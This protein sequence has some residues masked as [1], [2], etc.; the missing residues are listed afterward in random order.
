[1]SSEWPVGYDRYLSFTVDQTAA[2]RI[3]FFRP[4][5]RCWQSFIS[6]YADLLY[7]LTVRADVQPPTDAFL[8][9]C[10]QVQAQVRAFYDAQIAIVQWPKHYLEVERDQD[11]VYSEQEQASLA[12]YRR[13]CEQTAGFSATERVSMLW[14]EA[15]RIFAEIDHLVA[16]IDSALREESLPEPFV[17]MREYVEAFLKY[18]EAL[19]GLIRAVAAWEHPPDLAERLRDNP[20]HHVFDRS[21]PLLA[22]YEDLLDA[23]EQTAQRMGAPLLRTAAGDIQA[24]RSASDPKTNTTFLLGRRQAHVRVVEAWMSEK[25][26]QGYRVLI[27][28]QVDMAKALWW[29]AHTLVPSLEDAAAVLGQWLAQGWGREQ[30][31]DGAAWRRGAAA[32][33]V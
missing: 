27:K 33:G 11:Y 32:G 3:D 18:K 4:E 6:G 8:G 25:R 12:R 14:L 1:M 24:V 2:G 20:D 22:G 21:S 10:A 30:V 17:P 9:W 13:V 28:E 26:P 19:W 7:V 15:G 31:L 5:A 29:E 16:L 23:L